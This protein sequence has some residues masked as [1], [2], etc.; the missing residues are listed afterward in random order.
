MT[1]FL[2]FFVGSEKV[3]WQF[4]VYCPTDYPPRGTV[5]AIVVRPMSSPSK[6]PL[7]EYSTLAYVGWVEEA[8]EQKQLAWIP[9]SSVWE[10]YFLLK[11]IVGYTTLPGCTYSPD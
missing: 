11:D 2:P 3:N 7:P 9:I 1:N 6:L 8:G 10:D 4:T 5:A